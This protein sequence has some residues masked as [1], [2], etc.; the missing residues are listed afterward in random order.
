M[1]MARKLGRG[2]PS[3]IQINAWYTA[4]NVM[5]SKKPSSA[6]CR[7]CRLRKK[8][9][10]ST[11]ITGG[12]TKISTRTTPW[13]ITGS[14]IGKERSGSSIL[15]QEFVGCTNCQSGKARPAVSTMKR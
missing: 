13:A 11:N 15:N 14:L 1:Q 6:E 9:C 8:I 10:K 12:G 2:C 7:S 4:V 3:E 5:V